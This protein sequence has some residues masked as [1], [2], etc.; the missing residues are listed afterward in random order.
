MRSCVR[1]REV[2][3]RLG[4][5]FGLG[6]DLAAEQKNLI[7]ADDERIRML[8]GNDP[9]F[10]SGKDARNIA[11][12]RPFS[13]LENRRPDGNFVDFGWNDLEGEASRLKQ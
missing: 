8:H 5:A 6:K 11:P 9:R 3:A 10:F 12:L 1:P 2:F 7:R 13:L 4:D